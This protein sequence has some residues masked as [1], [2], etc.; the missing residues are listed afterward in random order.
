M[1]KKKLTLEDMLVPME[2]IPYEVPENWC[3]V[4]W[5]YILSDDK[6]SMKRGPFGSSLKKSFF[7]EK[8]E[9]TYKVYEQKCGH[10]IGPHFL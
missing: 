4:R 6:Y 7:V 5:E 2:E 3:W 9:N 1:A 8:G 10:G